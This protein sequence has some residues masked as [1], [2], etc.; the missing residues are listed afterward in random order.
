MLPYSNIEFFTGVL[1]FTVVG[2]VLCLAVK[3]A[4]VMQAASVLFCCWYF[5]FEF[6]G[7]A[8][9]L[10]F[11]VSLYAFLWLVLNPFK[12]LPGL[13]VCL[14]LLFPLAGVKISK[15]LSFFGFTGLSFVTFRAIQFYLDFDQ[16]KKNPSPITFFVF[17]FFP[18]WLMIGPLDTWQRFKAEWDNSSNN[19]RGH[20][21]LNGWD[22][23]LLGL[24]QKLV[25]AKVVHDF[26]LLPLENMPR[27]AGVLYLEALAYFFYL[28]F[29][30]AG[31]S[32][33]AA[34]VARWFGIRVPYNFN[35]PFLARNPQDFWKRWH[36]SLSEWLGSYFFRPFYK[37]INTKKSISPL[38]KQNTGLFLTF[39]LMGCWNGFTPNFVISGC[40][41]GLYSVLYNTYL[42]Q[43]RKNGRDIVFGS[44][45]AKLVT[46]ISIFIMFH[47]N[48]LAIYIFSGLI[49]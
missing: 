2:W 4:W 1:L 22:D 26:C 39:L 7:I 47:L 17:L 35:L 31:Y 44:M 9:L 37:W 14:I 21:I 12:F 29:D 24:V 5:A 34:G 16:I 23:L 33:M 3:K 18:A 43:C 32:N 45:N 13:L 48:V 25:L 8:T 20:Y 46:V 40:V 49:I 38:V 27:H 28:Y 41:F 42:Y 6:N 11:F 30:F 19:I 10:I 15:D 36:V